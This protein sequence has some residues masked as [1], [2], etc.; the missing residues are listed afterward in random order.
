VSQRLLDPAPQDYGEFGTSVA[1]GDANGD[2]KTDILVGA[3]GENLS[4]AGQGRAYLFS[5]NDGSLIR[6]VDGP[7]PASLYAYGTAS[8]R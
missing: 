8:C 3:P 1:M 2:G 6:I 7:D 4:P 5:G